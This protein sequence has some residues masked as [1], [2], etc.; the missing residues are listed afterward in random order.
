MTIVE[1]FK[2]RKSIYLYFEDRE[3]CNEFGEDIERMIDEDAN[4][5]IR[6]DENE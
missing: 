6:K 5:S 1:M 2:D 4:W 3:M